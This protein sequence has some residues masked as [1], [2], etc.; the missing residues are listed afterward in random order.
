MEGVIEMAG[1]KPSSTWY[2]V[3]DGFFYTVTSRDK[4]R[5]YLR[6]YRKKTCK[7]RASMPV[8]PQERNKETFR[9]LTKHSHDPDFLQ[10]KLVSLKRS[11][12]KRCAEEVTPFLTIWN[13][14]TA[15]IDSQLMSELSGRLTLNS[16]RSSMYRARTAG[17]PNTPKD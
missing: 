5:V 10:E 9:V 8:N 1:E 11:I 13:E 6:C 4:T 15:R 17:Q 16:L 2:H 3:N 12:L 7:S 14:E